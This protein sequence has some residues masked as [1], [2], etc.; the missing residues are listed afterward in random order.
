[1]SIFDKRGGWSTLT[2]K[3]TREAQKAMDQ[4]RKLHPV[5]EI[6]GS[7]KD[8]QV[9]HIVPVWADPSLAADPNNF[10]SLSAS[11]HIHCIFGHN[12]DFGERY[13]SNIKEIASKIREIRASIQVV[14]RV[15]PVEIASIGFWSNV[16]SLL[17]K[18]F[19]R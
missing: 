6:T 3:Q 13:V 8:V 11:A 14:E 15:H 9:H 17:K 5:C 4:Y 16:W 7:D 12:G 18:V 2:H 1:M 10:I 19:R